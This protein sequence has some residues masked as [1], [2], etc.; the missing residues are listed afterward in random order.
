MLVGGSLLRLGCRGAFGIRQLLAGG[1]AR[2]TPPSP[3]QGLAS[4]A[5][6]LLFVLHSS[7]S[8]GELKGQAC[9]SGTEKF[10]GGVTALTHQEHVE[11]KSKNCAY[12]ALVYERTY[13]GNESNANW[14]H[15]IK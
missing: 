11:A 2:K 7:V 6:N 14:L 1:N 12:F 15:G 13:K 8:Q 9:R 10:C 4:V 5:D 3:T